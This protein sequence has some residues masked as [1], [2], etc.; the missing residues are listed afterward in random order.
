VGNGQLVEARGVKWGVVTTKLTGDWKKN[1]NFVTAR[2][3]LP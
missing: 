3:I 1:R 2:R